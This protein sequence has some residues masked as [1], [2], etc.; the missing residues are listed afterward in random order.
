MV[1]EAKTK[2]YKP[3]NQKSPQIRRKPKNNNYRDVNSKKQTKKKIIKV[4]TQKYTLL[5]WKL[6]NNQKL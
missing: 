5:R 1:K 6:E 4:K 2:N 3:E